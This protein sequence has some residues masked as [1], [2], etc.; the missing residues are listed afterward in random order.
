MA[1]NPQGIFNQYLLR[2]PVVL[3]GRESARGLY[4]YPGARIA[5]IQG[6][7]FK[8]EKLFR[9]TFKKKDIRFF[10]RSWKGEPDIESLSGTL[11]ELEIYKPDT[12]IAI[13]GGSV[14]DGAKLCRLFLEFPYF[15]P[16]VT[17]LGI[18]TLT[19]NFIAVPT[20]IGSGAEV[21]SAAVFIDTKNHSKQ[22]V[23]LHELQP[24]VIV[25]DD[26]YV[27]TSSKRLLCTAALDAFAHIIEGYVSNVDNSMAGMLAEGGL[28]ILRDEMSKLGDASRADGNGLDDLSFERLQYAGYIGGIVQ[29]HCLVGAAHAVAH[30][31]TQFGFSHGE[32][33][34]LLLSDVIELNMEN[35][36]TNAKYEKLATRSGFS[37]AAD[38]VKLIRSICLS[39]GIYMRGEELRKIFRENMSNG[40]FRA[41]IKND[42]GGKGN[43][44]EITDGYINCLFGRI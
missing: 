16:G 39:S 13:G 6:M 31:L 36:N 43:P 10:H 42:R 1:W 28:S 9:E 14:I 23:V 40:Q 27:K 41:N 26:Y 44:I 5:V 20:T 2:T 25:Y 8:D 11:R 4:N 7:S 38:M 35:D 30:Q 19:T 29:N 21:S 22:M 24:D 15:I 37:N 32:A 12:I 34:G 33:V 17:R 3:S 18:S